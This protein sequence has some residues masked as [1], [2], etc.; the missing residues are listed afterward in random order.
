MIA[1]DELAAMIATLESQPHLSLKEEKYLELMVELQYR[2]STQSLE[3]TRRRN[4]GYP[5]E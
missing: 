4:S 2:R 1:K 5:G 3:L